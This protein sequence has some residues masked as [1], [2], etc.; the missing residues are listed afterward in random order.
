MST[1]VSTSTSVLLGLGI[2]PLLDTV[3]V[4][5]SG[6]LAQIQGWPRK[7]RSLDDAVP[8]L[9]VLHPQELGDVVNGEKVLLHGLF[10]VDSSARPCGM[11]CGLIG[12]SGRIR[13]CG[14]QGISRLASERHRPLDHASIFIDGAGDDPAASQQG[15]VSHERA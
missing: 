11:T 1:L 9:A 12:G 7:V 14:P 10:L 4:P 6:H 8:D 2:D 13:T 5:A 3:P 15:D